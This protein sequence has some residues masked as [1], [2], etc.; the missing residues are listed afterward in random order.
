VCALIYAD[1]CNMKLIGS[2]EL[3]AP[4]VYYTAFCG[5][6]I[7]IGCRMLIFISVEVTDVIM[8]KMCRNNE[9]CDVKSYSPFEVSFFRLHS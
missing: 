1:G 3:N 4:N 6:Y 8:S 5:I 7:Y 2:S 9:Y